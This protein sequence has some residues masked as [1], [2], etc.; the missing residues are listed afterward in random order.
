MLFSREKKADV[1]VVDCHTML[2]EFF[3]TLICTQ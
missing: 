3:V 2:E 1:G